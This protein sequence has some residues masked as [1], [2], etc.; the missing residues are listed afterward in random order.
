[1]GELG[2]E[3]PDRHVEWADGLPIVDRN[4]E[5]PAVNS[6]FTQSGTLFV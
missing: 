2:G 1:M 4:M 6:P 3:M 5:D